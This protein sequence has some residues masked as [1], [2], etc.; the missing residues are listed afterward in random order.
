MKAMYEHLNE[1]FRRIFPAGIPKWEIYESPFS[2]PLSAKVL[3]YPTE[4]C[5]L[6][7]QQYV[8][9]QEFMRLIDESVFAITDLYRLTGIT[10]EEPTWVSLPRQAEFE[11]VDSH[12]FMPTTAFCS[13]KAT[14]GLIISDS[15]YAIIATKEEYRQQL[16]TAF[17]PCLS[18]WKV[19]VKD[20]PP[21]PEVNRILDW[22][23]IAKNS[24]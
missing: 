8:C 13:H 7:K 22:V 6:E 12:R 19:L 4:V 23:G 18:Q 20:Y 10:P 15:E 21:C 14:W 24:D 9:L 3:L 16:F 5:M 2:E 11:E 1:A 17:E